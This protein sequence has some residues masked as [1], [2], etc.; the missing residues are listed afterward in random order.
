MFIEVT[1]LDEQSGYG[2]YKCQVLII[3]LENIFVIIHTY[4][5]VIYFATNRRH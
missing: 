3:S 2:I 1:K 5:I 4:I